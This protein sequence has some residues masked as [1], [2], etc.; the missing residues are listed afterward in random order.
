MGELYDLR[1]TVRET[2]MADFAAAYQDQEKYLAYCRECENYAAKWSCPPL[3]FDT[4]AFLA[5]YRYVSV[6]AVQLV[7]REGVVESTPKERVKEV[8]LETIMPVKAWFHE[9]MLRAEQKAPGS[10]TLS[11][12]GCSLCAVCTRKAGAP[13]RQPGRMRYS[14]DSFG[15]NLSAITEE[16]LGIKL[17]WCRGRLPAYYTLIHALLT[18]ERAAGA[19]EEVLRAAMRTR[20][21][22]TEAKL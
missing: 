13:C 20:N 22:L 2:R 10:V 21:E 4:A 8:T 14:L 6:A 16:L 12:G 17:L 1:L 5:P 7:F 3:G 15:F 19:V 11:S 9:V 18:R